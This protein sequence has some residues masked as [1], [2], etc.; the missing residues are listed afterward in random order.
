MKKR[1][2]VFTQIWL[3]YT[4]IILVIL[5]AL[6]L[7]YPSKQREL[8]TEYKLAELNQQASSLAISVETSLERDD[9]S[10]LEK[11]MGWRM[12]TYADKC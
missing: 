2:S 9:L 11:T 5:G 6:F 10:G 3:P 12:L 1:Y 8:L 7:Y 4:I